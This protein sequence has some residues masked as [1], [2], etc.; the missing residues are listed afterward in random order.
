V[1]NAQRETRA[2]TPEQLDELADVL[3]QIDEDPDGYDDKFKAALKGLY[4]RTLRQ[5]RLLQEYA[6]GVDEQRTALRMDDMRRETEE[7]D[8]LFNESDMEDIFGKGNYGDMKADSPGMKNR[9]R[10][11]EQVNVQHELAKRRGEKVSNRDLLIR[12]ASYEFPDRQM[13]Q[14]TQQLAE[15]VSSRAS[16]TIARPSARK[17]GPVSADQR[18]IEAV[19]ETM[20]KHGMRVE[21]DST[22]FAQF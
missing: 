11:M 22:S 16:Q 20:R 1:S 8:R 21:E 5:D 9:M 19:A 14:A 17:S 15:K 12:A 18:A 4:E 10:V 3:K 13:R 6:R 2:Q 7:W